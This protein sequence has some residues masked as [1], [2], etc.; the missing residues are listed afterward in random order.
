MS[1]S[2]YFNSYPLLLTVYP[3]AYL[4]LN[5]QS[6]YYKHDL[7]IICLNTGVYSCC[8]LY[9]KPKKYPNWKLLA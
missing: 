6:A 8:N 7:G 3:L 5:I 4:K 2:K 1:K 9:S